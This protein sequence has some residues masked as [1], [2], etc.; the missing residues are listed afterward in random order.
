M[1][2]LTQYP[3]DSVIRFR[4]KFH[5]REVMI[6]RVIGHH[7]IHNDNPELRRMT[8]KILA[9]TNPDIDR[10]FDVVIGHN[11]IGHHRLDVLDRLIELP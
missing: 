5:N 1:D 11:V 2:I 6:G 7:D 9:T 10:L 8:V 3:I 4:S